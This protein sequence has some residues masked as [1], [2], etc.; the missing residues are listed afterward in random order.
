MPAS[1]M[2]R[3]RNMETELASRASLTARQHQILNR[4][5]EV[6]N[7]VRGLC[8]SLQRMPDACTCHDGRAHLNGS[9]VCC[10]T[11]QPGSPRG[12]DNCDA[13]LAG[14]RPVIDSLAIDTYLFFPA[15]LELLEL[16]IPQ[17]RGSARRQHDAVIGRQ[18]AA[19]SVEERLARVIGTFER[20][21]VAAEEFRAGC[22]MSHLQALKATASQLQT[23]VEQLEQI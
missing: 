18:E 6:V 20:L 3:H 8:A 7:D 14:L 19:R 9:C 5:R 17:M 12:C 22:W 16:R 11:A 21:S 2:H 13:A 10:Q 4:W 23:A 1:S 15:V